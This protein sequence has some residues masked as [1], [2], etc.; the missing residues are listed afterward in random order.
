[1]LFSKSLIASALLVAS[2]VASASA[3]KE[4]SYSVGAAEKASTSPV[5]T[6]K[7]PSPRRKTIRIKD[8]RMIAIQDG[9]QFCMF[10]PPQPGLEIA[11]TEEEALAFCMGKKIRS[12]RSLPKD[13]IR[14]ESVLYQEDPEKKFVQVRGHFNREKYDLSA[15]DQGGQ[16]DSKNVRGS[17]CVGYKY[18]VSLVEPNEELFC[19]RCCHNKQDCP[20]NKSHLG[21]DAVIPELP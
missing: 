6:K 2:L 10:L 20:V 15:E 13:F 14:R 4:P 12:P 17:S 19:T 3:A 21:C 16:Y 7:V 8:E 1:M 18:F 5:I 11:P 9:K